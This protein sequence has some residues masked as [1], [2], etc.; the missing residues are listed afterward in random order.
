M[1][2]FS[3]VPNLRDSSRGRFKLKVSKTTLA[4]VV[5]PDAAVSFH[6]RATGL[7]DAQGRVTL[8]AGR[9][10]LGKKRGALILPQFFPQRAKAQV[11][12]ANADTLSFVGGF[13]TNGQTPTALVGTV[14]FGFGPAYSRA[15]DG[16]L[17]TKVA[18]GKVTHPRHPPS[19]PSRRVNNRA[20][21][22]RA[23][24]VPTDP[25][26]SGCPTKSSAR[27]GPRW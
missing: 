24:G 14:R 25:R 2:K 4:G 21:S 20:K 1:L 17:F 3:I 10:T 13:A 11:G 15:I 12:A 8:T 7:P 18:C 6:F 9:Y 27:A 19:E 22:T 5:N 26:S 23:A 16:T